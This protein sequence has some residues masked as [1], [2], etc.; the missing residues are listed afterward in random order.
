MTREEIDKEMWKA[1]KT[2]REQAWQSVCP[3]AHFKLDFVFSHL[4]MTIGTILY[5]ILKQAWGDNDGGK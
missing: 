5:K 2:A 4:E 1:F 3:S